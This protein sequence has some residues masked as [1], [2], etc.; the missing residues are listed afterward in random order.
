MPKYF[1]LLKDTNSPKNNVKSR[2]DFMFEPLSTVSYVGELNWGFSIDKNLPSRIFLYRNKD[3]NTIATF[4]TVFLRNPR[5]PKN[6]SIFEKSKQSQ[7]T[8]CNITV[9]FEISSIFSSVLR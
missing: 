4:Q 8:A 9:I 1:N 2:A 7:E 6:L 5:N 3:E